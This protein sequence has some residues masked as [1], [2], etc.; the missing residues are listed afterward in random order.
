MPQT[1][2]V[3]PAML[4][5]ADALALVLQHA[6]ALAA[7]QLPPASALGGVLAADVISDVDSPP[8]DKAIVD[9]YAVCSAA[10]G[11]A[12]ELAASGAEPCVTLEVLEEVTAGQLPRCQVTPGTAARVMTGAP[13]P[14]GADAMVMVEQ[15]SFTPGGPAGLGRVAIHAR[16][17]T[18]GQNIM[19]R[20]ASFRRGDVAIARGAVIRP[21]EIGVCAEVG[22]LSA[23]VVPR[24]TVAILPTGDELVPPE[25]MP[26]PGQIRNSNGPLLKACA[27]QAG[28]QVVDLGIG[29]DEASGLGE[30]MARGLEHDVLVISGG[31]SAGVSDL[32]PGVLR[33]LQ[34]RQVFHKIQLKPGKPLWFGVRDTARQRALVFGLP[35]NPVSSLVCFALFVRP[36]LDALAGRAPL[37]RST[38]AELTAD[39]TQHGERTTYHP[40]RLVGGPDGPRVTPLSWRGS[41]D[42][43]TLVDANALAIF[44]AGSRQYAAGEVIRVLRF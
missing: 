33:S 31:V 14:P 27:E 25:C 22:C 15:T 1:S 9:G 16:P 29:P 12:A 6:Q 32:V 2:W 28:A 39:Y 35:G 11:Q 5:V 24:P 36:A 10:W 4:S 43:R 41:G 19:P 34:V 23:T 13:I 44:P 17:V 38:L 37:E 7:V 20:G 18:P 40:A 3:R 42:L 30:R 8:H 26:G 21:I